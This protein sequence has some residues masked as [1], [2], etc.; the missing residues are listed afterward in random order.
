MTLLSNDHYERLKAMADP[1]QQTWD[2]SP[3]DVQAI[4]WAVKAIEWQEEVYDLMHAKADQLALDFKRT[5]GE[6]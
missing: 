2:L 6:Q 1:R 4:A 3:N 5:R